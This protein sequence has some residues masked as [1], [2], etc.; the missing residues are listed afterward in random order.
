[1][2]RVPYSPVPDVAPNLQ[3]TRPIFVNTPLA[4][5]G[6]ATA[7][8]EEGL[9]RT[10][11]EA[12]NE[13]GQRALAMQEVH[14]QA[15]ARAAATNLANQSIQML[16]DFRNKQGIDAGPQAYL[17]FQKQL[18]DAQDNLANGLNPQAENM[19]RQYAFS[20][21]E[22]T[23]LYAGLHSGAQLD[24]Y[25]KVTAAA[26]AES[27]RNMVALNPADE[28]AFDAA[29][30]QSDDAVA[31]K[32]R[33]LGDADLKMQQSI[34]RSGVAVTR[35]R[36][37]ADLPDGAVKADQLLAK[38]IK[39]GDLRGEDIGKVRDYVRSQLN[40]HQSRSIA[41]GIMDG[42]SQQLGIGAVPIDRAREAIAAN[43]TG[44]QPGQGY[45]I[46]GVTSTNKAGQTGAPLGRYGIMSYNLAPWLAKAGM[47][48]MTKEQFLAN[49]DAQDQLFDK[50]FGDDME[51][52]GSF[53][54]AAGNWLGHGTDS[55]GTTT[56]AYVA[57]ANAAL[58]GKTPLSEKVAAGRKQ[59]EL[60]APDDPDLG[61]F[62]EA[63]IRSLDYEQDRV[64]RQDALDNKSAI[65]GAL[66]D[67]VGKGPMTL[68]T[69]MQNPDF[70]NAYKRLDSAHQLQVTRQIA[71]MQRQDNVESDER[72]ANLNRLQGQAFVDPE[73]FKKVDLIGENLTAQ[74]RSVLFGQQRDLI[75]GK[76]LTD[77]VL[78]AALK[79]PDV[80]SQLSAA[81]LNDKTES[82][83]K[84][85]V[86]AL[87]N[88][89]RDL[90]ASGKEISPEQYTEITSRLLQ[91]SGHW[92][93][94]NLTSAPYTVPFE[95]IT[96]RSGGQAWIDGVTRDLAQKLGRDPTESEIEHA[97]ALSLWNDV[98]MKAKANGR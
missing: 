22:R 97:W 54:K 19:Y 2:A 15:T 57:R 82:D 42:S 61:D 86:G 53:N 17:D 8:A 32:Y 12:G 76:A 16:T 18:N 41:H 37:M 40:Q 31:V 39:D 63:R 92:Y 74:Q 1:M 10:L 70:A 51:K 87:A 36:A 4:A 75:K 24:Q 55:L 62:V 88:E 43:E 72:T 96:R 26:Q 49:H 11:T 93:T 65:D 14:N 30:K 13:L 27:A 64:A 67:Q 84:K 77:P 48:P 9:G 98:N 33:G 20:I 52:S 83:Y 34:A 73:G 35:I 21:F 29:L 85:F 45:G 60:D 38:A 71:S 66:L 6:G 59:A 25:N 91:T 80:Q 78:G 3:P 69:M 94:F 46:V 50:I 47:A 23:N 89:I 95:N 68:T 56:A 7:Q 79:D 81:G 44:G 28:S 58:G 5:F 90:R